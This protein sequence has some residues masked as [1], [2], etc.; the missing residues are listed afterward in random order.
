VRRIRRRRWWKERDE[1]RNRISV[2]VWL[3]IDTGYGREI[4][5]SGDCKHIDLQRVSLG[6]LEQSV[7]RHMKF[8]G[9]QIVKCAIDY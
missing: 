2:K 9:D 8:V 3:V 6:N 4:F 5:V 7:Y 1:G